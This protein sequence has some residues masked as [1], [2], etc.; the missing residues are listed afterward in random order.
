M[1]LVYLVAYDIR[2]PKRLRL[3][4]R[5]MRG[6]GDGVQYSVFRCELSAMEL[7]RLKGEL[8]ALIKQDE[9]QI[10][11]VPLGPPGGKNDRRVESLGLPFRDRER[12]AVV[13]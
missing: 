9:D 11:V 6:Y 5:K 13:V 4:H 7:A 3:V 2:D 8:T 10:L 12:R 1:R